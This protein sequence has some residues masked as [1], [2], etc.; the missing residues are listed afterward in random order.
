MEDSSDKSFTR[1]KYTLCDKGCA[2]NG[3]VDAKY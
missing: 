2:N 1:I 3:T